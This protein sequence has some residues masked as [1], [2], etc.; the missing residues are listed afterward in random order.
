[1]VLAAILKEADMG[2]RYVKKDHIAYVTINRPEAHNAIDPET[3][4]QLLNAWKDYRDDKECRC[5]I[6]TGAGDRSFCSGMDLGKM[7]PLSTGARAPENDFDRAV[8]QNPQ[9]PDE[10]ILRDFELYKPVIAAINGFAVAAGMELVQG[11]D[12]RIASMTARFGLPEVKRAITPKGGSTVRLPRQIPYC[13]TM[14]ILLTGELFTAQQALEMGFINK[15]VPAEEV[16]TE[17]EAIAKCI[18][19]NG[20]LAV[21]AVKESVIKTSG[22]TIKEGMELETKL[23]APVYASRDA[24]EG[25][26]AFMEKRKPK[27]TGE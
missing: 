15:V 1:M 19:E 11:T 16:M 6:I 25:P 18:L 21:M 9:L 23:A 22:L 3:A 26:R 7:I 20:P 8:L 14:E 2:V 5:A 17:A 12:I 24:K 27:Y 4:V 10:A 13:K